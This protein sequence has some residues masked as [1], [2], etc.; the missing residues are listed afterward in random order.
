MADHE[1]I[2]ANPSGRA[3]KNMAQAAEHIFGEKP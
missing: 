1:H 3:D 2:V